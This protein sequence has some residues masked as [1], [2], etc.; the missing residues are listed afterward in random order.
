LGH[1]DPSTCPDN[2]RVISR[3]LAEKNV[4]EPRRVE[5]STPSVREEERPL[6]VWADYFLRIVRTYFR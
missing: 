6:K 5:K 4:E 1:L 3:V 2:A